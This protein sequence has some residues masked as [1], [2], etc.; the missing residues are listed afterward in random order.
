M[1]FPIKYCIKNLLPLS[2]LH[3]RPSVQDFKSKLFETVGASHQPVLHSTCVQFSPCSRLHVT[4]VNVMQHHTLKQG[5][6]TW[7][8]YVV[9]M[10]QMLTRLLPV[11]LSSPI[12]ILIAIYNY[13]ETCL[14]S[15]LR[16]WETLSKLGTAT[17]VPSSI[18]CM[19]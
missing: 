10:T 6:K 8:R 2:Y 19:K 16:N 4:A 5:T 12:C 9:F 14:Y 17:S 3:F 13:S 7:I 15:H 11:F 18:Q 1:E